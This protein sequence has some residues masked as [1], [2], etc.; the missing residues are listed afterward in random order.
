MSRIIDGMRHSQLYFENG[1]IHTWAPP[2]LLKNT[3]AEV[4]IYRAGEEQELTRPIPK[5]AWTWAYHREAEYFIA[6]VPQSGTVPFF[7]RRYAD[8]CALV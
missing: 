1:W 7:G 6:N 8:R 3:P 4:E 2:L 5:P